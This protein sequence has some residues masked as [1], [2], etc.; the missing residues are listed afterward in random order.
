MKKKFVCILVLFLALFFTFGCGE[1]KPKSTVTQ[2]S[3]VYIV[4]GGIAGLA[5]AV[6][7]I[8][9]G[10][11]PGKNVHILEQMNF[12]G[13]AMDGIADPANGYKSRGA[14]LI[15]QKRYTCY[16]DLLAS[17]P[18]LKDQEEIMKEGQKIENP[19]KYVPKKSVKDEIFEFNKTHKLNASYSR[20]WGLNQKRLDS[21]QWTISWKDRWNLVKLIVWESEKDT[22]GKRIS[23]YMSPD[24]FKSHFWY[25]FSAMFGF[26]PWHDLTEFKRYLHRF[27]DDLDDLAPL[28]REGWNSP[29]ENYYSVI[30]PIVKWLQYNG[31]DFQYGCKVYDV[32]FK[33]SQTEKTVEKLYYKQNGEDK[34]VTLKNGDFAII[35]IGSKVADSSLGTMDTTAELIT[36]K[37]DGS[38]ILWEN[39]AKK[40][41]DVM[42]HPEAFNS[43][44]NES[45]WV[46]WA[47]TSKSKF[48]H[49]YIMNFSKATVMGQ[50]HIISFP[51]SNWH[52]GLHI[53]FQPFYK[54]QP[55]D[56]TVYLG[57]TLI[58]N[59]KGNYIKKEPHECTGKELLAEMLYHFGIVDHLDEIAKESKMN[60]YNEPYVVSHWQPRKIGD[61]PNVVPKGSTNFALI[62]EYVEIPESST[63]MVDYSTQSAMMGIYTLLNVDKK[64]PPV[65]VTHYNPYYLTKA[66]YYISK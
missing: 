38:W 34:T 49:D 18:S 22:S 30:L 45:K 63:F 10:N 15:N 6:F 9:D 64:I 57:Y 32:D 47:L 33:P 35:N 4:G 59:T 24:F 29:Y 56:T 44:I 61:R 53:P 23:D 54:G 5:A 60:F 12:M 31:V 48:L 7:A 14:R 11:I 52:Y 36:D 41:P 39:M 20:I 42:G 40:Q 1:Q 46:V 26:D 16:W 55:D 66:L 25:M 58:G 27:I 21:S 13:G 43:N 65:H 17:I 2:D 51:E 62:G 37:R 19:I 50:Q 3:Q 28:T 8:R